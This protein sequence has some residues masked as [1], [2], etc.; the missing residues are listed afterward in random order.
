M[1]IFIALFFICS[2]AF[3]ANSGPLNPSSIVT[4]SGAI[5]NSGTWSVTASGNT[6]VLTS[7]TSVITLSGSGTLSPG[8]QTLAQVL[9]TGSDAGGLSIKNLNVIYAPNGT[10]ALID[11][12]FNLGAATAFLTFDGYGHT[13]FANQGVLFESNLTVY[14]ANLTVDQGNLVLTN[15]GFQAGGTTNTLPNQTLSGTDAIITR[16]LGDARYFPTIL[17]GTLV[18]GSLAISNAL[19]TGHNCWVQDTGS[20]AAASLGALSLTIS[21]STATI[22][23]SLIT[24]TSTFKLFVPNF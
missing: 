1:K 15:G 21:G 8:G 11:Y 3:C 2:T 19:I 18:S 20:G 6:L 10:T 16:Q 23:S 5:T 7:G 13:L 22:R 14:Q 9:T 12:S 24:D 4:G 17:T